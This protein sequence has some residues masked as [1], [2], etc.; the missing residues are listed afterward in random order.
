[1]LSF[2]SSLLWYEAVSGG[3]IARVPKCTV[4][5]AILPQPYFYLLPFFHDIGPSQNLYCMYIHG[6]WRSVSSLSRHST[7][8]LKPPGCTIRTCWRE[9]TCWLFPPARLSYRT[10]SRTTGTVSVSRTQTLKPSVRPSSWL[11][12]T[13]RNT[14]NSV[15]VCVCVWDFD[16][17]F[18]HGRAC[19][20]YCIHAMWV[21]LTVITPNINKCHLFIMF[22]T[23]LLSM[24]VLSMNIYVSYAYS[25]HLLL[26]KSY[27]NIYVYQVSV[28]L[29]YSCS[30]AH[31]I[32][33]QRRRV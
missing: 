22:I 21:L 23:S 16:F 1:M 29:V 13:V 3:D 30:G 17:L 18:T 14:P 27:M 5:C 33:G 8:V 9:M 32:P 4:S 12:T 20:S 10:W 7:V 25:R 28:H 19:L 31:G 6:S 11:W 2:V 24:Q 26:C 15:C